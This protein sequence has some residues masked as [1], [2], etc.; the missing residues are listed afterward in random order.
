M[1]HEKHLSA[2]SSGFNGGFACVREQ[3]S[4]KS[5]VDGRRSIIK[6]RRLSITAVAS[7]CEYPVFNVVILTDVENG[8]RFLPIA[9]KD[10]DS[11]SRRLGHSGK[12][13]GFTLFQS[14][15]D[16]AITMWEDEWDKLLDVIRQK[17]EIEVWDFQFLDINQ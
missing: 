13:A 5:P 11:A 8:F 17:S 7:R 2:E 12:E 16:S 6:E 4:M 15:I 3:G 9:L 14:A 1:T 10:A